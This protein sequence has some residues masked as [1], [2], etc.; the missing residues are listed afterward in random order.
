MSKNGYD[1]SEPNGL[2]V[3]LYIFLTGICLSVIFVSGIYIYKTFISIEK[4]NYVNSPTRSWAT[5]YR[6]NQKK[7][8]E[9]YKWINKSSGIV[10][11]PIN[12]VIDK[13]SK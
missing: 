3:N 13:I 6:H 4:E 2:L 8:L 11:V 5:K 9:S 12:V 10:Q 7:D 1:T